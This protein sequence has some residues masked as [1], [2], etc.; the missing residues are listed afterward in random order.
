MIVNYN[1]FGENFIDIAEKTEAERI[2]DRIRRIREEKN[3]K[4]S[5]GDLGALVGLNANR[6]QQYENGA[7]KPK[8]DM[9]KKIA[10]ALEV[11]AMA[12]VDPVVGFLEGA[13]YGFFEME[14]LYGLRLKEIDGQIHIC[15]GNDALAWETRAINEYLEKWYEVQKLRNESLENVQSQ[16]G[17]EIIVHEYNTWEETFPRSVSTNSKIHYLERTIKLQQEEIKKLKEAQDS[18]GQ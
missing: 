13:M 3:P 4:M 15:F 8:P 6:I 10:T 9:I 18:N 14:K 11:E 5:Q 17:R 7:R 1:I 2:G 16:E 12:L